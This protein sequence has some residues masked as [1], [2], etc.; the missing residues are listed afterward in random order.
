MNSSST[1]TPSYEIRVHQGPLSVFG[2]IERSEI[3]LTI[4]LSGRHQCLGV[5]LPAI[6]AETAHSLA[7]ALSTAADEIINES[8]ALPDLF[9]AGQSG[10]RS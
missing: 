2:R 10:V 3:N 1:P 9:H 4:T 6:S 8:P 7:K 5:V